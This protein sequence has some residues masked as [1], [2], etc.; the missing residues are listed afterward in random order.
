MIVAWCNNKI[1]IDNNDNYSSYIFLTMSLLISITS[2][3]NIYITNLN[4]SFGLEVFEISLFC[5]MIFGIV[6]NFVKY[7]RK[8]F[9]TKN[10]KREVELT[11]NQLVD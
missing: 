8:K 7:Q 2:Q 4:T 10:Y 5:I 9:K 1:Y 11:S 6:I 3:I